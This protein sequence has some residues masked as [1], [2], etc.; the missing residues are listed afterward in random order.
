MRSSFAN[1]DAVHVRHLIIDQGK[2]V[3]TQLVFGFE[4]IKRSRRL[5]LDCEVTASLPTRPSAA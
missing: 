4:Q 2:E 1:F 3:E 5:E